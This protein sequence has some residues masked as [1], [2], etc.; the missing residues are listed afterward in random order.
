MA[1]NACLPSFENT[2]PIGWMS[3][4]R[5]PGDLE[6]QLLDDL[7]RRSVDNRDGAADLGRPRPTPTRACRR[8]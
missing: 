1:T 6:V 7:V 8:W 3:S 2:I 4:G 5:T